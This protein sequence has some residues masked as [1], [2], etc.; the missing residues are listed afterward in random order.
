METDTNFN[1]VENLINKLEE[2]TLNESC[3]CV[4]IEY[5]D[6]KARHAVIPELIEVEDDEIRIA[7]NNGEIDITGIKDIFISNECDEGCIKT[8]HGDVFMDFL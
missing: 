4:H 8:N 2:A 5:E 7:Y 3:V 1:S 6:L